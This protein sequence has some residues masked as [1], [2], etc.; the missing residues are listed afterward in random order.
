MKFETKTIHGIKE[1]KKKEL[2]ATNLN[3]A[4][5]FPVEKFG[6]TQEFE[7]SRVS[8]PTRS[9][10]EKL[11]ANLEGGKYGYAFSSGMATTTSVFTMFE[12]GDHIVLGQ[13]IYG[14]TYRILNDV[15]SKFG[16]EST[17]VDTTDLENIRKAIKP[18][19]K[20]ILIETPSNPLLD[21][22]DIR[23]VVKLAKEH[24]LITIVDN[25]FMTPYLQRPLELGVDIV[26]HSATKFLSGHHDLLAGVAVTNDE[27]LAEKIQFA[28]TAAGALISPFDSWL[29]MRSLKT[30][31]LRVEAA[32]KNTEKLIEFFQS[33]DAV[34]KI[35]YPTL[36]TNKGKKIHESQATGGGAVFSF[37]LKDDSKV[38]TF[39]ESLNVAL[40][41]A[42]L[43]GAETLVTHPSTITHA[44]MPEEEKEARGFTHS[45]IRIAVGFEN[46]DD[47]IANI[48]KIGYLPEGVMAC[49]YVHKIAIRESL[50]LPICSGIYKILNK[51]MNAQIYIEQIMNGEV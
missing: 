21:V 47:L 20:A 12:A 43:G 2:W 4:S 35:Y 38:K 10:L 11:L 18:N 15:Y 51:E 30:L 33:H 27:K 41:A 37:T 26:I 23:G 1:G 28:Q 40:F 45:L 42:S 3:F 34:D 39:F 9:Q 22:T 24:N 44:E 8:A 32:Q 25:T 16:V 7:Y 48:S 14:G 49:N 29:L 50:K 13:D 19:T 31:K 46:I 6:V 36:D 5:T 17:F